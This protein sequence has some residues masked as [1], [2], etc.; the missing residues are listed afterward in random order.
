MINGKELSKDNYTLSSDKKTIT[1]RTGY[2]N[3]LAAGK[4]YT[5]SAN[6][7]VG[8]KTEEVSVAFTVKQ[9]S[10]NGR[11]PQTGDPSSEL[12]LALLL[13]SGAAVTALLPRLKKQ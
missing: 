13:L 6:V 10:Y 2:L 7:T 5:I 11:T 8:D 1:L 12:W 3:N 9:G 4:E